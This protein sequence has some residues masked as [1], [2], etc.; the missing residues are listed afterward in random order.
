MHA[1]LPYYVWEYDYRCLFWGMGYDPP[2]LFGRSSLLWGVGYDHPSL[3][4][5]MGYDRPSVSRY[6]GM[7]AA[8]CFGVLG[9]RS[10][11]LLFQGM[12]GTIAALANIVSLSA[13]SGPVESGF[14]YFLTALLVL[15]LALL[16]YLT[17]PLSVSLTV[18]PPSPAV[19]FVLLSVISTH[20]S[21]FD[22]MQC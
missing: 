13:G 3:F 5:C 4:W 16:G 20:T 17:L 12:G 8:F 9:V 10:S 14:G 22:F 11:P 21:L 6:G 2:P 15:L 19:V 7:I 1:L 18:T